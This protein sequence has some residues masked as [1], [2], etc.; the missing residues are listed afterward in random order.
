MLRRLIVCACLMV[1]GLAKASE[2]WLVY[3][4]DQAPPAAFAPYRLAVL[5]AEHYLPSLSQMAAAGTVLLGYLSLG[6]AESNRAYFGAIKD[7]GLLLMENPNWPGSFFLDVRDPRWTK[8]LIDELIPAVLARGFHG[9]FM[10]TLDNPPHLE[11]LDPEKY[12]G[13]TQAAVDMVKAIR[14]KFPGMPIM[15][16]RGFDLLP[17]TLPAIDL[18]LG[19]SIIGGY[20]FENKRYVKVKESDSK[21]LIKWLTDAKAQKPTLKVMT[22]DYADPTDK[23]TIAAYYK[24]QRKNGFD[25]YVATIA[26]DQIIPEPK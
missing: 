23:K 26:L 13:M 24:A 15:Q 1:P 19:E 3:Y 17:Q 2:P 20:D 25:P 9:L 5:D 18:L 21:L 10:D 8:R 22:L 6:E 7:D 4:A 16:N 12:K 11:R 14:A